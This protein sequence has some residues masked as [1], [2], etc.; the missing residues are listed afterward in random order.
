M[1]NDNLSAMAYD[2]YMHN[3]FSKEPNAKLNDILIE[4][5]KSVVQVGE[6]KHQMANIHSL[7]AVQLF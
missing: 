6:A 2:I 5:E 4:A 1:L 7:Q 3:F